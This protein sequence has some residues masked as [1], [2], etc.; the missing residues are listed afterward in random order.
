MIFTAFIR[1]QSSTWYAW[2]ACDEGV[3][4]GIMFHRGPD[5]SYVTW[6]VLTPKQVRAA[7]AHPDIELEVTTEPAA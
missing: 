1:P 5:G 2:Q 6:N 4:A 3:L 7:E